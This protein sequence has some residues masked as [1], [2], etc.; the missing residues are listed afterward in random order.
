MNDSIVSIETLGGHVFKLTASGTDSF[1][2]I[3]IIELILDRGELAAIA[4]DI[5][6]ALNARV[7]VI[8]E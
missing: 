4:Y 3:D 8:V 2:K 5:Q 1:G 7:K 6:K